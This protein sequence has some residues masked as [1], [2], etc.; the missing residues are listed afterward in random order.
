MAL[1]QMQLQ[2]VHAYLNYSHIYV[3]TGTQVVVL[4]DVYGSPFVSVFE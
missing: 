2:M 1:T 4:I 3:Q